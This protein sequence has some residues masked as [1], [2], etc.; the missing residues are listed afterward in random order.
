MFRK[1][2][3]FLVEGQTEKKFLSEIKNKYI[4]SGKIEVWNVVEKVIPKSFIRNLNQNTTVVLVFDT[5]TNYIRTLQE[6]INLLKKQKSA[7]KEIILI[8]QIGNLEDELIF[9]TNIRQIKEL[10][11]S[12]S[13]TDFKSDF[14]SSKNVLKLL[15]DK[16]FGISKF[17][18]RNASNDFNVYINKAHKIKL[19]FNNSV[20]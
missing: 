6:N 14:I 19:G 12:K 10:T 4:Q 18:S 17:W 11:K 8:S 1:T 16:E 3:I 15:E 5:D 7:V 9:A 20:V 2:L 13:N